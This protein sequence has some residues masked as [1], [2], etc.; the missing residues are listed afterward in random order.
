MVQT[1]PVEKW[2]TEIQMLNSWDQ[3]IDL[4]GFTCTYA[5]LRLDTLEVLIKETL[6]EYTNPKA[7]LMQLNFAKLPKEGDGYDVKMGIQLFKG[8]DYEELREYYFKVYRKNPSV[9]KKSVTKEKQIT[10]A[11]KRKRS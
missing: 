5:V 4:R 9:E 11:R 8:T 7:G 2:S 6:C 10:K 3:P 1:R